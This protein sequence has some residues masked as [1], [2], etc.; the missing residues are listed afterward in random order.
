[1]CTLYAHSRRQPWHSTKER[2]RAEGQSQFT[3]AAEARYAATDGTLLNSSVHAIGIE[4]VS[5]ESLP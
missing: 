2:E 5:P 1:M 3:P 4:P